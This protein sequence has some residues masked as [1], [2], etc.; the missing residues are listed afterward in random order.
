M[1]S[2]FRLDKPSTSAGQLLRRS[3]DHIR[4][5]KDWCQ[6]HVGITKDG[7]P[8][9]MVVEEFANIEKLCSW[10]A[11]HLEGQRATVSSLKIADVC[12]DHAASVIDPE[13]GMNYIRLNDTPGR[14]HKDI[15]AM[16]QLA[17]KIADRKAT[18]ATQKALDASDPKYLNIPGA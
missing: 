13:V 9:R 6:R 4:S 17:I 10:G 15:V 11:L 2:S 12:L 8:V 18:K 3:F 16:W 1:V 14:S 7:K 5:K